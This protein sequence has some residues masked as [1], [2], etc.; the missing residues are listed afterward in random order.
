VGERQILPM[1]TN[2]TET[3][4]HS[5]FKKTVTWPACQD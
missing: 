5:T 4:M 3:F 1:H 2:N